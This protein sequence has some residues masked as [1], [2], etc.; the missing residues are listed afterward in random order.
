VDAAG[1]NAGSGLVELLTSVGSCVAVCLYDP[2]LECGGLAHVM[3]PYSANESREPLPPKCA[4]S[5]FN[6]SQQQIHVCFY[7]ASMS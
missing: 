5:A 3:L 4:D 7:N 2:G 1:M 6:E